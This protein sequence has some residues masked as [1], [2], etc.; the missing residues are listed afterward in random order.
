MVSKHRYLIL[1]LNL[2]KINTAYKLGRPAMI[3][4]IRIFT[5]TKGVIFYSVFPEVA[6]EDGFRILFLDDPR[7]PTFL[8][9]G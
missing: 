4:K 3:G 7:T 5:M 8:Q 6:K 2:L 9:L 1:I